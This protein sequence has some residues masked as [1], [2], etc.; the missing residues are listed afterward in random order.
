VRITLL[1]IRPTQPK[2]SAAPSTWPI[3][4]LAPFPYAF[5]SQE[6]S[7][8]PTSEAGIDPT[9]IQP[10]SRARTFPMRRCCTAPTVL[11][12]APCAMSVPMAVV[13]GIPKTKTRIG[14]MSDP[15]PIP[16]MP[17]SSPV[18]RPTRTSCQVTIRLPA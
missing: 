18:R 6:E 5:A 8:T 16:V 13:G 10:A 1:A 11:K 2:R 9:S 3:K 12:T 7:Q 4:S 17:T 14:V 15:P